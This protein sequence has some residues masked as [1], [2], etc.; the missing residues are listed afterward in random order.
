MVALYS[1]LTYTARLMTSLLS[2][3]NLMI[4][5]PRIKRLAEH[6]GLD[7]QCD[8]LVEEM[9]ELIV[10]ITHMKKKDEN[11]EKHKENFLEEL[12]D[13]KIL[14]S[15]V[16]HLLNP[17]QKITLAESM[18]YKINREI[19]RIGEKDAVAEIE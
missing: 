4:N 17:P 15:E 6:Y 10:A 13:V 18:S 1:Q 14:I 11:Y 2:G 19:E 3:E 9:A 16:E 12:G 7:W 8:K 5:D